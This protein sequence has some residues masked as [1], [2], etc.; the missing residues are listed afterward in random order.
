LP[1]ITL[2]P[3]DRGPPPKPGVMFAKLGGMLMS[4]LA[5][6]GLV[7]LLLT[8]SWEAP[9]EPWDWQPED[10]RVNFA[11]LLTTREI[12]DRFRQKR[13]E[14][15]AKNPLTQF[16]ADNEGDDLPRA[17]QPKT[18]DIESPFGNDERDELPSPPDYTG[19]GGVDGRELDRLKTEQE[20][21]LAEN[22]KLEPVFRLLDETQNFVEAVKFD[23][24]S[25]EKC[26]NEFVAF[27]GRQAPVNEQLALQILR[28]LPKSGDPAY[29][30]RIDKTG[31]YFGKSQPAADCY[32]G[33]G[34]AAEGRL[35]DLYEVKPPQ[36]VVL[37]DGTRIESY[38]EGVV[39]LLGSGLGRGEH[40]IEQRTVLFQC[41]AIPESLKS[42]VNDT[43]HVSHDDKLGAEHV[44]V[45]LTGPYLRRWVYSREVKP[46]SSE[47][48]KVVTQDHLPLLL[49]ADITTSEM[50]K[51]EL[52]DELLQQ[53]RDS[54]REDPAY[55]ESEA[56]YYAMLARA[57]SPEDD[58]EV[59][60]EIGYFDLAGEETGPRYRG[61]GLRV[62][63]MVGD[64]YAPVILPPNISGLRRVFRILV[65]HDTSNMETPKRYLVD[66]IEP[67]TN[68]EPRAIIDMEARYYR[69]VFEIESTTSAV[70]PLLV[71]R[72]IKAYSRS[73]GNDT[74]TYSFVGGIIVVTV[75]MAVIWF[76]FSDRRE[77]ARFEARTLEHSRKRLEK[78][79]GLKLK[80]LP[81]KGDA[82]TPTDRPPD[83]E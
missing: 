5:S 20:L 83:K 12:E 73:S 44:M 55:L 26:M 51:Y 43:G 58:I 42:Y 72:Q 62:V 31:W 64:N 53:V 76:V 8:F 63:G 50:P 39:A 30:A 78:Q 28:K 46:F 40:K 16:P 79:G 71:V 13:E 67:P 15:E 3:V 11:P 23:D 1:K 56:A 29:T 74:W 80:R 9:R 82:P 66:M 61:Q 32:R 25:R 41:L 22:L 36:P 2:T 34:F 18:N 70:R 14:W 75:L 65:L 52:T 38:F 60:P 19:S 27:Q 35:F 81:G 6:A 17:N 4:T 37:Q 47:A 21:K 77:R 68:L 54:L 59:V 24:A 45:K 69:N 10:V 57:N 33:L 7:Y 48:K 49:T